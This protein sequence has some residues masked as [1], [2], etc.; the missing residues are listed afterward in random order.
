MDRPMT[1]RWDETWHRLREW[2]NGQARA[3][4]LAAQVL[5]AEG[6]TSVDPSHPLGGPDGGK[7]AIAIKGDDRWIMA[8]Y[9]PRGQQDFSAVRAKFV[10][11]HAGVARNDA[12]GIA[13]VTNQELSLAERRQLLEQVAPTPVDLFHLERLTVILDRPNMHA[14]RQQFLDIDMP[15]PAA[16]GPPS[17][18]QVQFAAQ[19]LEENIEDLRR[20]IKHAIPS[21]VFW[22]DLLVWNIYEDY[23]EAL[24]GYPDVAKPVADAYRSFREL[25]DIVPEARLGTLMPEAEVAELLDRVDQMA[26]A[27]GLLL[28]LIA[29]LSDG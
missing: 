9:F 4:K 10:G 2:T 8:A 5:D 20:R 25:N 22:A 27:S 23:K 26:H 29:Q 1:I 21:R 3:E 28:K 19:E 11:D 6:F 17:A 24:R 15:A 12:T 18:A 7:D 16:A 13:F 14:V